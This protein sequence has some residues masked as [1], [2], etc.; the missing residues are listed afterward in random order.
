[1]NTWPAAA[2]KLHVSPGFYRLEPPI[3]NKSS[4]VK[5]WCNV[6]PVEDAT[7]CSGSL[8]TVVSCGE[9]AEVVSHSSSVSICEQK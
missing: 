3:K 8:Y 7:P 6:M 1:M 5:K 2:D 4:A 9:C